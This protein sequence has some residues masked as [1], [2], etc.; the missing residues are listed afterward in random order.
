MATVQHF[1]HWLKREKSKGG[2]VKMSAPEMNP[3]TD[4]S[5]DD[6]YGMKRLLQKETTNLETTPVTTETT[7]ATTGHDKVLEQ[8]SSAP[9]RASM[10]LPP[11]PREEGRHSWMPNPRRMFA[12]S[13]AHI[14]E[15]IPWS[16][17]ETDYEDTPDDNANQKK[18]T[19]RNT[20]DSQCDVSNVS[21]RIAPNQGCEPYLVVQLN[22]K[23]PNSRGQANMAAKMD[24]K[25]NL[26]SKSNSTITDTTPGDNTRTCV[27]HLIVDDG[28]EK[29]AGNFVQCTKCNRPH[30]LFDGTQ[31]KHF[32]EHDEV[33][34]RDMCTLQRLSV[35]TRS[36]GPVINNTTS[37][38]Q[39]DFT[40][41]KFGSKVRTNPRVSERNF[42]FTRGASIDM[43]QSSASKDASEL[44]KADNSKHVIK[45]QESDSSDTCNEYDAQT[46]SDLSCRLSTKSGS[47]GS[48]VSQRSSIAS[49]SATSNLYGSESSNDSL[50]SRQVSRDRTKLNESDSSNDTFS[51]YDIRSSDSYSSSKGMADEYDFYLSKIRQNLIL[52]HDTLRVIRE[53]ESSEYETSEYQSSSLAS[54]VYTASS[55]S[56]V[57]VMTSQGISDVSNC[58]AFHDNRDVKLKGILKISSKSCSVLQNRPKR[59]IVIKDDGAK[60]KGSHGSNPSVH[61]RKKPNRRKSTG[62]LS[63]TLE[64]YTLPDFAY[65][66]GSTVPDGIRRPNSPADSSALDA[67]TVSNSSGS[68]SDILDR[69]SCRATNYKPGT[70][71]LVAP[72]TVSSSLG[73]AVSAFT[74][75]GPSS[76]VTIPKVT[77]AVVTRAP[78]RAHA[79]TR[80]QHNRL[81]TDIMKMNH[82][83]QLLFL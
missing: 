10:K 44:I 80:P 20:T 42:K 14:Y 2:C 23:H 79:Q 41:S 25:D 72:T 55:L 62:A 15:E 49:D 35:R 16:A 81:L 50:N 47:S 28:L 24:L 29:Y 6:S 56:D 31:I 43:N 64:C 40:T 48:N 8:F 30:G 59:S 5:L 1:I 38:F 32:D 68:D 69:L 83:R 82:D 58:S 39:R 37:G 7:T 66:S 11:I 21:S 70:P 13:P 71:P 65:N 4:S 78:A 52:K 3:S 17:V 67:S 26:M 76:K 60:Y 45:A 57:S 33:G 74:K 73:G 63:S 54:S 22:H 53:S 51:E 19:D 18:Q 36:S 12:E 77:A 61:A 9:C 46:G 34:G 75:V 27:E